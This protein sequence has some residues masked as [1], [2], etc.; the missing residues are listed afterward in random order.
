VRHFRE[1]GG[2]VTDGD[3]ILILGKDEDGK[4]D[5]LVTILVEVDTIFSRVNGQ[6]DSSFSARLLAP[7]PKSND[8]LEEEARA[9]NRSSTIL[10]ISLA[11]DGIA[12]KG[13]FL[14]GGDAE[15]TIWELLWNRYAPRPDLLE[16]DFLQTPHHCSWHSLSLRFRYPSSAIVYCRR[17]NAGKTGR[18]PGSYYAIALTPYVWPRA[19]QRIPLVDTDWLRESRL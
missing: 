15:V 5:D 13:R 6:N 9:K 7:Q 10:N 14:T 8:E 18:S 1:S 17:S 3:R 4:T 16:Y 2:F 19:N 11:G 12:D